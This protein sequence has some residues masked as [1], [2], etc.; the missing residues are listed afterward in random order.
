MTTTKQADIGYC[1]YVQEH[2]I[3]I[4][5]MNSLDFGK[6]AF[7]LVWIKKL[8]GGK[9]GEMNLDHSIC[10]EGVYKQFSDRFIDIFVDANGINK[11]LRPMAITHKGNRLFGNVVILA[12]DDEGKTILLTENQAELAIRELG[13]YNNYDRVRFLDL[14]AENKEYTTSEEHPQVLKNLLS[15]LIGYC[16]DEQVQLL[17][18]AL[19]VGND[20]DDIALVMCLHGDRKFID[21]CH[22]A[23]TALIRTHTS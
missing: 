17:T 15:L 3:S 2:A 5:K 7:S 12:S 8:I 23:L 14:S 20:P 6:N 13:V 9:M 10:L 21:S 18:K 19:E 16:V 22:Q 11:G 4:L 1:V